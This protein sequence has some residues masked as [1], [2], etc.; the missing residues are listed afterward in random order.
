MWGLPQIEIFNFPIN[1]KLTRFLHSKAEGMDALVFPWNCSLTY[2][3]PP[4]S[5][6]MRFLLRLI[7]ENTLVIAILPYWPRRPWLFLAI[8]LS[9]KKPNSLPVLPC[10]LLQGNFEYPNIRRLELQGTASMA[11]ERV[12]LGNLGFS[13]RVILTLMAIKPSTNNISTKIWDRFTA[14]SAPVIFFN[15]LSCISPHPIRASMNPAL[16]A[17]FRSLDTQNPRLLQ[18]TGVDTF[19]NFTCWLNLLLSYT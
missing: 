7:R 8:H 4:T 10:L 18:P 13:S 3:F 1:L 17:F 6:I 12:R 11:V 2:A 5:L 19:G 9:I 15:L 14:F 16:T